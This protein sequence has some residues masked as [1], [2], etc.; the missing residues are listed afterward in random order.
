MN[1]IVIASI[2]EKLLS[3]FAAISFLYLRCLN[4]KIALSIDIKS[5]L[6]NRLPAMT[7]T[8][9]FNTIAK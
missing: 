1:K 9:T 2:S 6:T 5:S 3:R 7:S 4:C 8:L